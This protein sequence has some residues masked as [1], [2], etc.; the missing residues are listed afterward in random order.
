ME[1]LP[2]GIIFLVDSNDHERDRVVDDAR[3][4]LHM[5][6]IEIITEY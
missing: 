1:A 2:A 6:L 5:I 3:D 4:E